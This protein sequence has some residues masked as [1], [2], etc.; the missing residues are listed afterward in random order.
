MATLFA[1]LTLGSFIASAVFLFVGT[2]LEMIGSLVSAAVCWVVF[3]VF[4]EREFFR[5]MKNFMDRQESLGDD[6]VFKGNHWES[7]P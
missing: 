6:M 7:S 4:A 2:W 5:G 3:H 1:F